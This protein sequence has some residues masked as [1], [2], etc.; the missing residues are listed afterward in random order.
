M[1]IE[2]QSPLRRFG[3]VGACLIVIGL[4]LPFAGRAYL[5]AHLAAKADLADIQRATRLEPSNAEYPA[6]LGRY[7]ALSGASLDGAISDF[8]TAVHL[9]P[10]E[11]RYWLDLASAYHVAGR[12]DEQAQSVEQAVEADPTTPNVAWAAANIFLVQGN[13]GKALPYFRTVLGNDPDAVDWTLQICWRATGDANQIFDQAL[14]RRTD[15]YLSFLRLLVTK[16]EVVPAENAWDHLIGLRQPFP[17]KLAFPYFQLLIAKQEVA[18]A[19]T[20]WQ[21]L[22]QVDEEIQPYLPSRENLI[23]NGGFEENLL[24]GGFDWWYE[25]NPHAALAIDTDLFYGGTRSLSVTFDGR[26]APEAGIAQFIPVKPDTDYEFSAES[27]TQDIDSASGPRFAI[28]DAYTDFSYVLT[29]D[30]LGTNPWHKQHARFHTG[31]TTNLLFLKVIRQ[32]AAPL[33][34]GKLWI[35]DVRLVE[36][37]DQGLGR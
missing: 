18:A 13:V 29:D 1:Q 31:P 19:K 37:S 26:N 21:Q 25:S 4:Y 15:L 24:N 27:K 14:P 6:L 17:P 11:S 7:F 35:D 30:L 16:Q 10:Y 22:A 32:P 3:F 28:A 33:I 23:V 36:A 34:R 12:I 9:N 2:L 5:A 8:R 20:A